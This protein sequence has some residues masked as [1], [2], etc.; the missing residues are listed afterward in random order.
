MNSCGLIRILNRVNFASIEPWKSK[1]P[2]LGRLLIKSILK[3]RFLNLHLAVWRIKVK[4][5][6]SILA[7]LIK[8]NLVFAFKV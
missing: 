7:K 5:E 4:G 2:V 3:T 1:I 6:L 8:T